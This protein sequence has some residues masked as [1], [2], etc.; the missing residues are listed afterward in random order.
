MPFGESRTFDFYAQ[1]PDNSLPVMISYRPEIFPEGFA[2]TLSYF[3]NNPTRSL[4]AQRIALGDEPFDLILPEPIRGMHYFS[5]RVDNNVIPAPSA[6][7]LLMSGL[8]TLVLGYR[9]I[10]RRH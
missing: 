7:A 5:L 4:L 3:G 6:A 10:K 2:A 9:H 1:I 8:G